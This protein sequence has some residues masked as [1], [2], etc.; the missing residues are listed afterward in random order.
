MRRG[1]ETDT[2]DDICVCDN[3]GYVYVYSGIIFQKNI[4]AFSPLYMLQAWKM[5]DDMT[6]SVVWKI[7]SRKKLKQ[8]FYIYLSLSFSFVSG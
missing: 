5:C 3:V 4:I 8:I 6:Q 2:V 1:C 7:H